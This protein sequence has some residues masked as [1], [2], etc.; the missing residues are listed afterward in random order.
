[1]TK[2]LNQKTLLRLSIL[3]VLTTC[4]WFFSGPATSKIR[5]QSSEQYEKQITVTTVQLQPVEGGIPVELKCETAQLSAPNELEKLS[6][7]IKNNTPN[8]I[9]A[10]AL[11]TS[12][13]LEEKGRPL[14][15]STFD[16]F[17]TSMHP[18][19]R[20]DQGN[21]LI[22]PGKEYRL[23]QLPTTYS[24][25]TV[26]KGIT[27]KIN[28]IEF[29]DKPLLGN[30]R[31]GSRIINDIREGAARYKSWLIQEYKRKG[32]SIAAVVPLLDGS[33]PLPELGSQSPEQ[34]RGAILYRK[35]FLKKY[36]NKG[37]ASLVKYL[38]EINTSANK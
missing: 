8:Y 26:I 6:C 36:K 1:M 31:G 19:F 14:V 34:E 3:C 23:N 17:D 25:D 15:V 4:L 11:Y 18:D 37:A 33:L 2:W 9:S 12:I 27:V 24:E 21:N 32:E 10:G 28:Y 35:Y 20:E 13:T 29:A 16:T 30:S 5:T 38:K 7:T 22:A